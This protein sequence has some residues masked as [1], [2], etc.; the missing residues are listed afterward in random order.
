M[1]RKVKGLPPG[2]VR[3]YIP[4]AYGNRDE[5][6]PVTVWIRTPITKA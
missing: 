3:E 2:D 1:A 5:P 4:K 6:D